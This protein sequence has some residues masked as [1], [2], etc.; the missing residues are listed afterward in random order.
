[1]SGTRFQMFNSLEYP[2]ETSDNT[3]LTWESHCKSALVLSNLWGYISGRGV[4][5]PPEKINDTSSPPVLVDN[6][7]YEDWLED[8]DPQG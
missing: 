1:M 4:I 6:P 5:T 2:T 7:K 3:W 8:K